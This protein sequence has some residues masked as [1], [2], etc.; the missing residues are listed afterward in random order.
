MGVTEFSEYA[1]GTNDICNAIAQRTKIGA[2][3]VIGGGDSAAAA[4]KLGKQDSF[5]FIS[6]GGGASLALIEGKE[7][8][9][10]ASIKDKKWYHWWN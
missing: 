3:T 2:Y 5:S 9:G 1:K 6:T 8:E 10:I 4:E 7:L